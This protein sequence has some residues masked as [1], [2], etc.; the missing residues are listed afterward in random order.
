MG[1]YKCVLC[2]QECHNPS[3]PKNINDPRFVWYCSQCTKTIK[4]SAPKPPVKAKLVSFSTKESSSSS[5][6]M[7]PSKS[8]SNLL[9]LQPFKRTEAV[10][11]GFLYI[12]HVRGY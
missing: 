7:P 6:K 12:Y 5:M 4:K 2:V 11:V 3:P 10:K 1:V 9:N 8:D